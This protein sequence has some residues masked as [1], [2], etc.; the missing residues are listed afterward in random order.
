M[1]AADDGKI[2][3]TGHRQ[4][5]LS[6]LQPT[7][8]MRQPL[9]TAVRGTQPDKRPRTPPRGTRRLARSTTTPVDL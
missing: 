2:S 1:L 8:P 3:R 9:P 7:E 4:P 6:R 5:S